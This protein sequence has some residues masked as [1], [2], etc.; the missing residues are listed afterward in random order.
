[1]SGKEILQKYP[2]DKLISVKD[3]WTNKDILVPRWC[4]NVFFYGGP[5][6]LHSVKDYQCSVTDFALSFKRESKVLILSELLD[7]WGRLFPNKG[8]KIKEFD[9][10]NKKTNEIM[11]CTEYNYRT[12]VCGVL[13]SCG[14]LNTP[15]LPFIIDEYN[16][17]SCI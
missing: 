8:T 15:Q 16:D 17:W 1:M 3:M 6:I 9:W 11:H 7:P 5:W 14:L 4:K 12:T 2:I 10:L 13:I